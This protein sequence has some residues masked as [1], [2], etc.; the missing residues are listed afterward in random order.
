MMSPLRS[1][2]TRSVQRCTSSSGPSTLT[3]TMN[4]KAERWTPEVMKAAKDQNLI[5][6]S[7]SNKQEL[8]QILPNIEARWKSLSMEQQYGVFRQLEEIQRKDWKDL[9]IDEKKAAYYVSFGPHG[10]RKP[11]TS[12]G[13]GMRTFAGVAGL[14]GATFAIFFGLRSTAK[15]PVKTM[16][17]EWQE[18]QN[19]RALE[20]KQNPITGISSEGY[21]GPG[22]VQKAYA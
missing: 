8:T 14:I 13:Q 12:S 21:K 9:S 5:G 16:T 6:D 17:T 2:L 22:H 4:T 15:P 3:R 7:A 20:Q 18:Q 1:S 11:I 19:E 10:P